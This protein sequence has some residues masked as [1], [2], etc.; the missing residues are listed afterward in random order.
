MHKKILL[1]IPCSLFLLLSLAVLPAGSSYRTDAVTVDNFRLE[2]MN[3]KNTDHG[4]YLLKCE[5][6]NTGGKSGIV[7][8]TLRSIDKFAYNRK[9]VQLWGH[10]KAGQT[11][12][13]SLMGFMDYKTLQD[14]RKWKVAKLEVH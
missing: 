11:T 4:W 12:T 10:L 3:Y 1:S 14:I 8:V 6:T 5:V 7:G 9:D 13:L 2:K